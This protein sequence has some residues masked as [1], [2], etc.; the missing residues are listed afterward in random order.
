MGRKNRNRKN[1]F[2]NQD[3][4]DNEQKELDNNNSDNNSE[5]SEDE[6]VNNFIKSKFQEKKE[7]V[8]HNANKQDNIKQNLFKIALNYDKENN[9]DMAIKYYKQSI[10][11]ENKVV[12][13]YNLG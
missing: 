5:D 6:I 10:Q 4:S 12:S 8:A 7:T 11:E 3:N 2:N 13:M 9:N 1:R